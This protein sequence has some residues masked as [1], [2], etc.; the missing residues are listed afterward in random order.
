MS[1]QISVVRRTSAGSRRAVLALLAALWLVL[2]HVAGA[3]AQTET[4]PVG[5]VVR[6]ANTDG[7]RLN[8]RAGASTSQLVVVQLEPGAMATVSGASQTAEGIRWLPIRT[9]DNKTGWV[10]SQYVQVVSTPAP[11]PTATRPAGS[12]ATPTP[13][14]AAMATPVP[15]KGKP[16]TVEAKLKFP[17][18]Q[19]REQEITVWVTRDN[20]PVPGVI[21]TL[22]TSDGDDDEHFRQL[23]PTDAEGRTRRSFDVRREKGTVEL[24]VQAVAPDGGEGQVIVSYFRR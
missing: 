7:Q 11:S 12:S 14:P 22:E 24:R 13:G 5:T 23:D 20:V 2:A 8:V 1:A 9:Q 6:V 17:E 18:V 4:F 15:E 3:R 16:L 19:G 21:V 10:S